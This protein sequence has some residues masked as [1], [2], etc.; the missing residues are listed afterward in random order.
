MS[1]RSGAA[2]RQPAK[3]NRDATRAHSACVAC[4]WTRHASVRAD[5]SPTMQAERGEEEGR[6]G[7]LR[8]PAGARLGLAAPPRGAKR[9][10]LDACSH[11]LRQCHGTE[12]AGLQRCKRRNVQPPSRPPCAPRRMPHGSVP[13]FPCSA[14]RAPDRQA[15]IGAQRHSVGH[16]AARRGM[17]TSTAPQ[18]RCHRGGGAAAAIEAARE[19]GHICSIPALRARMQALLATDVALAPQARSEGVWGIHHQVRTHITPLPQD[20]RHRAVIRTAHA[21]V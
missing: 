15:A 1:A 9:V 17:A 7:V 19:C 5:D 3:E 13:A 4:S 2:A 21:A 20:W 14:Y 16:L 11:R 6:G 10:H 12:P 18:Q 8:A